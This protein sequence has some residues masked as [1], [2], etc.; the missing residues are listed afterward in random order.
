MIGRQILDSPQLFQATDDM[1]R[2]GGKEEKSLKLDPGT[3]RQ[4]RAGTST[5]NMGKLCRDIT[6][7]KICTSEVKESSSVII[8]LNF[9]HYTNTQTFYIFVYIDCTVPDRR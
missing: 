1:L 6:R 4:E 2:N 8:E 7:Q 3:Q 5:C 9:K